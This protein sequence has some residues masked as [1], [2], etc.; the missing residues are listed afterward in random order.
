MSIFT[1]ILSGKLFKLRTASGTEADSGT[2]DKLIVT[3]KSLHDSSYLKE[4][5]SSI[6]FDMDSAIQVATTTL[7]IGNRYALTAPTGNGYFFSGRGNSFSAQLTIYA[8]V[9]SGAVGEISLVDI[10]TGLAVS[11]SQISV[12]STSYVIDS[13]G[14]FTIQAGKVYSYAMR[15]LSGG[16]LANVY[17]R[18]ALITF[19][20]PKS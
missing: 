19:S 15:R 11:G 2:S 16:I 5:A 3:P 7:T 9:D 13:S 14:V 1:E 4:A 12:N 10:S 6:C 8:K 17:L 18:T 20:I